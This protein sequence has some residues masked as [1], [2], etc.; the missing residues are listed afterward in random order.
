MKD[1]YNKSRRSV[2]DLKVHLIFTT[3]YRHPCINKAMLVDIENIFISVLKSW[4]AELIE[5][6]GE[7]DH[8]HCIISYPPHKL[9]SGIVGNMKATVTKNMWNIYGYRLKKYY[10][11][12]R[13]L[14]TPA[15]FAASCGGVTVEQLKEYVQ[16]QT[17]P[18]V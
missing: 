4:G 14:W 12:K 15:Y 11:K 17:P 18:K 6:G 1:I 13:V 7:V 2:Y 5:F 3:K 10:W 9:L 16:N 8:I